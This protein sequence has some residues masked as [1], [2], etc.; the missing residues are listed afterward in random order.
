MLQNMYQT[1][2]NNTHL[3]SYNFQKPEP[4]KKTVAFPLQNMH[5]TI[6]LNTHLTSYTSK[7]ETHKIKKIVRQ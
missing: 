3:I 4:I 7:T 6:N 5:Q 2:N 1:F